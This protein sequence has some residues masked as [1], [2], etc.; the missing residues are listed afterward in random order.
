MIHFGMK[1]INLVSAYLIQQRKKFHNFFKIT[2]ITSCLTLLSSPCSSQT[3]IGIVRDSE[4]KEVLPYAN[5]GVRKKNIGGI[6]DRHGAFNID[7][8][9]S[10]KDDTVLISYVGY[11]SFALPVS[12]IDLSRFHSIDLKPSS[13][14]LKEITIRSK[15]D[16]IVLGNNKK[17]ARHSGW[18]DFGASRGRAIGVLIKTPDF[19]VRISKVVFHVNACEFDSARIRINLL[20]IEDDQTKSLDDQKQNI[21]L[22]IQKGKGWIEVP[23]L[24]DIVLMNVDV[25]V[26][27]E[28][29]DA[30]AKPRL[31]E[32]GG[33]YIFSISLAKKRGVHYIRQAPEE[34]IQLISSEF[35][36]SIYF[37]CFAVR[38]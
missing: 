28:W 35:T 10:A 14:E 6:T 21:F 4:T 3:F 7:L 2:L 18:G 9:K 30:W 37:E 5:I 17:T 20:K 12:T 34:A 27:I 29:V 25:I 15:P 26:A 31:M 24:E 22:T 36:P 16:V 32:E 23:M 11:K 33:S 1:K 8:S 38:D 13:Q 19:K